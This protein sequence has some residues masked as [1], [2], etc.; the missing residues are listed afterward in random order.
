MGGITSTAHQI[1][2][3]GFIEKLRI[4]DKTEQS[5]ADYTKKDSEISSQ[6]NEINVDNNNT[7]SNSEQLYE[8][9]GDSE[10]LYPDNTQQNDAEPSKDE[11]KGSK[12]SHEEGID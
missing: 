1:K 2:I 8:S 11:S 3:M 7:N 12:Q 4:P 10:Q 9:H 5:C 6:L